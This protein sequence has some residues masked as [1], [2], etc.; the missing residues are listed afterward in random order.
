MPC[1][2]SRP[3]PRPCTAPPTCAT[4]VHRRAATAASVRRWV[5]CAAAHAAMASGAWRGTRRCA[6]HRPHTKPCPPLRSPVPSRGCGQRGRHV[7]RASSACHHDHGKWCTDGGGGRGHQGSSRGGGG[8]GGSDS[9]SGRAGCV[10]WGHPGLQVRVAEGHDS[11][12]QVL[13]VGAGGGHGASCSVHKGCGKDRVCQGRWGGA[14]MKC[15]PGQGRN[16]SLS[17]T[18]SSQV[19]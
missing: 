3:C 1:P 16:T 10:C 19:Q 2:C 9:S 17:R 11:V 15:V 18:Q 4:T 8:G 13:E 7:H 14:V 5:P 12:H 6:V